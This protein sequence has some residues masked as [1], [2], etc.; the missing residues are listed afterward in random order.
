LKSKLL[1]LAVM[2]TFNPGAWEAEVGEFKASLVYRMSS[3]IARGTQ[4]NPVSGG[5]KKK[6]RQ[7]QG[8]GRGWGRGLGGCRERVS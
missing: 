6:K 1:S 2:H 3:R 5:E 7:G 8:W 4:R